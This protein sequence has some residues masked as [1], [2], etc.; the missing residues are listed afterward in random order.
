M[1][2]CKINP[3]AAIVDGVEKDSKLFKDLITLLGS[4]NRD[5]VKKLHNF[6][7]TDVEFKNNYTFY[8]CFSINDF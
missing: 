3:V 6:A 5:L 8:N 2:Y 7:T 4:N 1:L